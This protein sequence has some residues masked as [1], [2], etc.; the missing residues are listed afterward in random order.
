M[1]RYRAAT[2]AAILVV[3]MMVGAVGLLAQATPSAAQAQAPAGQVAGQE[4]QDQFVPVKGLPQQEQLP[5]STL[6]MAAYGFVWAVLLVYLWS[7]WRRLMKVE[8][9][10]RALSAR[11]G[12]KR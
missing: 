1:T 10:M 11:L 7:I 5:A 2:V 4:Q 12:Q 8:H 3:W 9:E 6:V